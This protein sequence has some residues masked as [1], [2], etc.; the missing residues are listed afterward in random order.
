MGVALFAAL[1]GREQLATPPEIAQLRGIS[2]P[3]QS[4]ESAKTARLSQPRQIV[5]ARDRRRMEVSMSTKVGD[6]VVVRSMPFVQIKMALAA[7]HKT[8]R[9]YP[10]FDPLDVFAEGSYIAEGKKVRVVELIGRRI[11]VVEMSDT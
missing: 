10:P 4:G 8:S 9:P 11:M 3:G 1:D 5:R 6:R 2:T 7:N